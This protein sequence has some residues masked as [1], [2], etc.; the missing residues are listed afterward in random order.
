MQQIFQKTSMEI[1][2]GKWLLAKRKGPGC[3]EKDRPE[4][5]VTC[6]L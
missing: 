3:A 2:A 5:W 1:F 4:F 6:K